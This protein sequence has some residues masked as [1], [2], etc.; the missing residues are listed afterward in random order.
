MPK[1]HTYY[2][3][4]VYNKAEKT[5]NYI[6]IYEEYLVTEIDTIVNLFGISEAKDDDYIGA[7][8]GENLEPVVCFVLPSI[9]EPIKH[10]E[11]SEAC[12]PNKPSIEKALANHLMNEIV[13]LLETND[14]EI[15]YS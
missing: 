7:I 2:I 5:I 15:R 14:E 11:I 10:I 13:D 9:N 12:V 1:T 8:I 6:H 4:L 3:A